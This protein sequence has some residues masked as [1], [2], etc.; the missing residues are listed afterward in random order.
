[1]IIQ[2]E[3]LQVRYALSAELLPLNTSSIL[4]EFVSLFM[5]VAGR[6]WC[7]L[8]RALTCPT[9]LTHVNVVITTSLTRGLTSLGFFLIHNSHIFLFDVPA[10][11]RHPPILSHQHLAGSTATSKVS[12]YLTR[13]NTHTHTGSDPMI[14]HQHLRVPSTSSTPRRRPSPSLPLS[15]SALLQEAMKKEEEERAQIAPP[16]DN[17][18]ERKRKVRTHAACPGGSKKTYICPPE[19]PPGRTSLHPHPPSPSDTSQ[20]ERAGERKK[21]NACY[22]NIEQNQGE[23]ERIQSETHKES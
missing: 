10:T 16:V 9:L 7:I 2:R 19:I 13:E 12:R 20:G 21:G 17:S 1:M 6:V 15:N 14:P 18:K 5:S 4:P 22:Q 11:A 3:N 8:C 23:R